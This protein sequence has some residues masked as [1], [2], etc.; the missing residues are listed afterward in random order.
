MRIFRFCSR[1]FETDISRA[2]ARSPEASSTGSRALRSRSLKVDHLAGLSLGAAQ[3][4]A[5][6]PLGGASVGPS[7]HCE[8]GVVLTSVCEKEAVRK[9]DNL[10]A[11]RPTAVAL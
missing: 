4:H 10:S 6:L 7:T 8:A 1:S 3:T 9:P 5:A 11:T 2:D